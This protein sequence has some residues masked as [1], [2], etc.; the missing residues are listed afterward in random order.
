MGGANVAVVND[1]IAGYWN[2]AGLARMDYPQ[3]S[4]MHEEH[5]GSIVDLDGNGNVS[6]SGVQSQLLHRCLS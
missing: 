1:V 2:P 6:F 3:I 4:L 5:F